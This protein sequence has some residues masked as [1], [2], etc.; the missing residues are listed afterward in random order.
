VDAEFEQWDVISCD[1]EGIISVCLVTS[2]GADAYN[3]YYIAR[4]W[5]ELN[6]HT[7]SILLKSSA[8]EMNW[9]KT[10]YIKFADDF[11]IET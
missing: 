7:H 6:D 3:M 2:V 11:Q 5:G 8:Q 4:N 9:R 1:I 10:G